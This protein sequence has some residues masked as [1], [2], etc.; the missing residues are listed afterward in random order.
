MKSDL[1]IVIDHKGL[2]ELTEAAK[3]ALGKVAFALQDDIRDEDI[4][5]RDTGALEETKFFVDINDLDQGVVR[6][7]FEGPYARRLYYH[8]EYN[9][10]K[11]H[12]ANAQ[13]LWFTP[14]LPGGIYE[15]SAVK[16]FTKLMKGKL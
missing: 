5:P 2:T 16:Y 3:Q 10:Q 8:P 7:V 13:A 14:W 11:I 6:L 12:N 15:D 4:I 9:F 1:Q